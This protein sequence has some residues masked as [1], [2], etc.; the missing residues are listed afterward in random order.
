[1]S[2][3]SAPLGGRSGVAF[4]TVAAA[5]PGPTR[6]GLGRGRP[7]TATS[8]PEAGRISRRRRAAA[9]AAEAPSGQR[10]DDDP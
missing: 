5:S 4:R 10:Q 6:R 3:P 8:R 2:E 1:M 7:A 9:E